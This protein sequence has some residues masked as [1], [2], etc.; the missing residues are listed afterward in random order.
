[1]YTGPDSKPYTSNWP[2]I[3][4]LVHEL[5]QRGMKNIAEILRRNFLL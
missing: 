2:P 1:L 3:R 5:E 4:V